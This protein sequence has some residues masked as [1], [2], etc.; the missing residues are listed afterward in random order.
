MTA[1][2]EFVLQPVDVSADIGAN[3]SLACQALGH[4]APLI[5]WHRDDG[6]ALFSPQ[7]E[8]SIVTQTRQGHLH[9][10]GGTQ[11]PLCI[12]LSLYLSVFLSVFVALSVYLNHFVY[13]SLVE[14]AHLFASLYMSLFLCILFLS[15]SLA[16]S[17]S[18]ALSLT[19]TPLHSSV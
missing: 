9:I 16:R 17:V 12:S 13:L 8:H 3:V 14:H 5:T 11:S 7:H 10:T 4:P 2:P 1:A 18:R 6:L 15:L 19:L